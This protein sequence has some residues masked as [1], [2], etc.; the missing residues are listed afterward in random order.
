MKNRK[1]LSFFTSTAILT[2]NS[3]LAQTETSLDEVVV[4][5][6][7]GYEQTIKEA[8]ASISVITAK[9]LEKNRFNSLQDIVADIP[10]VNVYL[11]RLV[12]KGIL[13]A[14]SRGEYCIEDGILWEYI[15]RK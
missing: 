10:G 9:D 6:A 4:T 12:D 14:H 11:R 1:I 2:A 15:Q 13:K 5:S 7:S 8:S 3:L